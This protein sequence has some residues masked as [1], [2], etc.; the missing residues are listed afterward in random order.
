LTRKRRS[1]VDKTLLLGKIGE[2]PNIE[3]VNKPDDPAFEKKH[4]CHR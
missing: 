2:Q 4:I 3:V 1:K